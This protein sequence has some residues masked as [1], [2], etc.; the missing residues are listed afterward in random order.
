MFMTNDKFYM[1]T[2]MEPKTPD[3]PHSSEPEEG[4]LFILTMFRFDCFHLI[5][6]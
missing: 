3:G 5:F 4:K 2:E 6:L 1:I